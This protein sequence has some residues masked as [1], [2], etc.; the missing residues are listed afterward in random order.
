MKPFDTRILPRTGQPVSLLGLG[1]APLG[2]LFHRTSD[3]DA[4]A[5]VEA[6][7]QAGVRLFD[8]APLYGH[9]LSEHRL[10]QA[11]R[12]RPRSQYAVSTK[13]GRLLKTPSARLD[14]TQAHWVDPLPFEPVFDYT[15]AGVRR[16]LED[17]LQRLGFAHVDLALV[18]DIGQATHGDLHAHYWQQLTRGGGL[19]ELESLRSEGLVRAIG[20]GVNE[21]QVIQ[22]VLDHADLDCALLAGRYTLLDQ[23]ALHPFLDLA[24]RRGVGIVIGGP[25]NSGVLVTGAASDAKF[26]YRAVPPEIVERVERLQRVCG[27]FGVPLAA[28]A[29]Q[30]PL[31]HP[32]VV[33]C[34]PGVRHADELRQIVGWLD[35]HLPAQLWTSLLEEGLLAAGTPVPVAAPV[36]GASLRHPT[37]E[38]S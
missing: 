38:R 36:A 23:S 25:F 1:C 35:E 4:L 5:V 34:I 21:W 33:S 14:G 30:F 7:W 15:A 18:H 24:L 37:R 32:A 27:R 29:L 10:G 11:L 19:R 20:V 17:S 13:V 16:S 6:A 28:A 9:G 12:E 31:A 8:T 2:N 22:N 3:A 26:D